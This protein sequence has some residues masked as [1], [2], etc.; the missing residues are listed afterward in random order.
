MAQPTVAS[1][2]LRGFFLGLLATILIMAVF[3]MWSW[4]TILDQDARDSIRDFFGFF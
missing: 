1:G 3:A 2:G 4:S